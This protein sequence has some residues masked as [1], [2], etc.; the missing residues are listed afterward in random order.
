[1]IKPNISIEECASQIWD[2]IIV[3]AGTAGG[4]AAVLLARKKL[5]V[6]LVDRQAFPRPKVCGCCLNGNA[7]ATLKETGLHHLLTENQAISLNE[8]C[9]GSK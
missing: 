1:M 7:I 6:L 3:G 9:L 2:V 8:M 5:R 4:L